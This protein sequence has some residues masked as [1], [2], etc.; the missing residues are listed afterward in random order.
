MRR[1]PAHGSFSYNWPRKVDHA[2]WKLRPYNKSADMLGI[3]A[4]QTLRGNSPHGRSICYSCILT[5]DIFG[6][7]SPSLKCGIHFG[8]ACQRFAI[9]CIPRISGN[10][11]PKDARYG[12]SPRTNGSVHLD[13]TSPR[14]TPGRFVW[15]SVD[16]TLELLGGLVLGRS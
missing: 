3:F 8:T 5:N 14:F 11:C 15:V 4:N 16:A 9:G 12:C 1:S 7:T 13:R 2:P 10:R 6:L